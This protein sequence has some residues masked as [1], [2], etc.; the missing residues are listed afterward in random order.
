MYFPEELWIIIKYFLFHNIKFSKHLKND[1][2]IINFNKVVINLPKR[3]A[4]RYGPRIMYFPHKNIYKYFY[5]IRIKNY[6]YTKTTIVSKLP[7]D[8]L[9]K[10]QQYDKLFRISYFYDL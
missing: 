1:P 7:D 4:P 10:F 2:D 9:E 8:Y 6:I 3:L 5:L